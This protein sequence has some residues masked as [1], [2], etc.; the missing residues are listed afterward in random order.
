M[1]RIIVS[2]LLAVAGCVPID[3]LAGQDVDGCQ[4]DVECNDGVFC[5]GNERCQSGNC[6]NGTDPCIDKVCL[7]SAQ[8]CTPVC[9]TDEDCDDGIFCNGDESCIDSICRVG[10]IPCLNTACI[11]STDRCIN[12]AI[13]VD[14]VV[15]FKVTDGIWDVFYHNEIQTC[16]FF[17]SGAVQCSGCRIAAYTF[18]G[19][20]IEFACITDGE[21]KYDYLELNFVLVDRMKGIVR[22]Q[23]C[24]TGCPT[25]SNLWCNSGSSSNC[26][27]EYLAFAKRR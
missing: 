26:C 17:N 9:K 24:S 16:E 2:V 18:K 15:E 4:T 13:I 1:K 6:V 12:E 7:E 14:E 25:C 27:V 3:P 5:N 20:S 23:D 8:A 11:E 22:E 21:T 19:D 10:Q